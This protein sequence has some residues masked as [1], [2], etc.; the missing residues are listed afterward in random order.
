MPTTKLRQAVEALEETEELTEVTDWYT[1]A[2]E[3]FVW[4]L[5]RP[6]LFPT[7]SEP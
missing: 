1:K 3:L 5:C 2:A 6:T 7:S 4:A